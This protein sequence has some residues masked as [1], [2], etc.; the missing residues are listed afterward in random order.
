MDVKDKSSI[1]ISIFMRKGGEGEFTKIINENNEFQFRQLFSS[2]K[3]EEKGLIVYYKSQ[4]EWLLLTN[5][6]VLTSFGNIIPHSDIIRVSPA[7]EDEFSNT[8]TDKNRFTKLRLEA[9]NNKT[10]ILSLEMGKAYLGFYQ[11]LHFI[12]NGNQPL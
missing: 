7:L 2:L 1:L 11:I 5:K 9:K 12:S 8:I 3:K 6:R 10:Y 4:T